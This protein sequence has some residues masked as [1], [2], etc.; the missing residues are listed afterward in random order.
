MTVGRALPRDIQ[1]LAGPLRRERASRRTGEFLVG[2]AGRFV[3][4]WKRSRCITAQRVPMP[5]PR[6]QGVHPVGSE[7]QTCFLSFRFQC[8]GNEAV[9]SIAEYQV[10][11]QGNLIVGG[12][13]LE[14]EDHWRIDSDGYASSDGEEG[15]E[16]ASG[17]EVHPLFHFQRGG[18]AQ[19]RF[20]GSAGFVPGLHTKL[21]E[22]DWK[23]LMQC[24]S[25]RIPSMPLD[26]ILAID[27]CIAQHDGGLWR[28]LRNVPEYFGRIEAAQKRLWIP[29]LEGLD[30]WGGRR[31]W[32]GELIVV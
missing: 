23:G 4:E 7:I 21:C 25:P 24:V 16:V 29:F 9:P 2:E 3:A 12:A 27:F 19:D 26:P 5:L 17:R 32:L 28:R 30:K 31:K 1:L 11:V 13:L 8:S 22:G 15:T 10:Q 14:L 6:N 18:H 20:A